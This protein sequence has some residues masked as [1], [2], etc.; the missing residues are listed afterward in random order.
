MHLKLS[1]ASYGQP[2][3]G[4]TCHLTSN[5]RL[6]QRLETFHVRIFSVDRA[7]RSITVFLWL[8]LA[9]VSS[10][11]LIW[12]WSSARKSKET[13]QR[14]NTWRLQLL[15]LSHLVQRWRLLIR[16]RS[17]SPPFI[18]V[19]KWRPVDEGVQ[20]YTHKH[21]QLSC[22]VDGLHPHANNIHCGASFRSQVHIVHG[23]RWRSNTVVQ[24]SL[25][26]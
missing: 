14:C 2:T 11:P 7:S 12:F 25:F 13:L 23:G 17:I 26:S 3:Y 20:R 1:I 16:S 6:N 15:Y 8:L 4:T 5:L 24:F 21:Y 10:V 9:R 22:E 18:T 19:R